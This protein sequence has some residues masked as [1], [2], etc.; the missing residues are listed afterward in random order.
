MPIVS[1]NLRQGELIGLPAAR[2]KESGPGYFQREEAVDLSWAVAIGKRTDE[3]H[4]LPEYQEAIEVIEANE[5]WRSQI[6]K[7]VGT[8]TT[9]TRVDAAWLIDACLGVALSANAAGKDAIEAARGRAQESQRYLDAREF[10]VEIFAPLLGFHAPELGRIEVTS[11]L[12]I[13][14]I[15]V[16]DMERLYSAGALLPT[17]PMVPFVSAPSHMVLATYVVPKIVNE[18]DKPPTPADP[19][20]PAASAIEE[21]LTCMRLLKPGHVE[22]G[23]QVHMMP[24]YL[25]RAFQR[26]HLGIAHWPFHQSYTLGTPELDGLVELWRQL[27]SAGV[28]NTR[29]LTLAARR[30]AYKGECARV[31]DQLVDL[32]VAAEALFLADAD[33]ESRGEL[34][35]RMSLR[36]ALFIDDESRDLRSTCRLFMAAYRMRSRLVHGGDA[37]DVEVAGVVITPEQ[38]VDAI[39][40]LLRV[41]LKRALRQA[42]QGTRRLAV[43]WDGLLF[44]R[45]EHPDS[46]TPL[47]GGA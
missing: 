45:L 17:M 36:A 24:S 39:D 12:A 8:P 38:M 14:P 19:S 31:D 25:G 1:A 32:I 41:A 35:F 10:I 22:I 44:E 42:S 40:G 11:E 23:G 30:F 18:G 9:Q 5:D 27:H 6:G 21:L 47:V 46:G 7:L 28:M 20:R 13:E 4:A 3:L 29:N 26:S 16:N 15:G 34:G 2:W 43:D 37:K 33:E